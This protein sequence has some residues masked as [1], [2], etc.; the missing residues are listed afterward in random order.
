MFLYK[1][2]THPSINT[3]LCTY[4]Y[5]GC[6]L[7]VHRCRLV[8]FG[9]VSFLLLLDLACLQM[10]LPAFMTCMKDLKWVNNARRPPMYC[11]FC[12]E[13]SAQILMSL[14]HTLR[15]L[16]MSRCD[17]F[18]PSLLVP[19][20]PSP[21]LALGYVLCYVMEAAAIWLC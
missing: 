5:S 14:G 7:L 16:L 19:C 6:L 12:G 21:S 20:S 18:I 4:L 17:S 10:T 1:S 11:N 15:A 2:V 13:T 8:S 9:T 3:F